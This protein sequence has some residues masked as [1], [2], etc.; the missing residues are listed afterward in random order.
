[1]FELWMEAQAPASA[2]LPTLGVLL[3]GSLVYLIARRRGA[4]PVA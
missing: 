2:A 3:A 4:P 1:V